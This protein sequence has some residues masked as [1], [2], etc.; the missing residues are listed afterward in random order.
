M[1]NIKRAAIFMAFLAI[2]CG[3]AMAA[4]VY[5]RGGM[6]DAPT[7]IIDNTPSADKAVWSGIELGAFL[8]YG[9]EHRE[10]T[11]DVTGEGGSTELLDLQGLSAM[12]LLA[13][14]E[15]GIYRQ[16]GRF[17]VGADVSYEWSN[18]ET[19][20]SIVGQTAT[21][22]QG[23]K[24][25]A[26][27]SIGVLVTD[28]ALLYVKGGYVN[29]TGAELTIPG[30]DKI[31]LD[32]DGLYIGGGA[33]I[34]LSKYMKA[35]IEYIHDFMNEDNIVSGQG[36]AIKHKDDDDTIRVGLTYTLGLD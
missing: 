16:L 13:G 36:F 22:D 31:K 25:R 15:V 26:G 27:G 14:A 18:M 8:G 10:I 32:T 23:E 3:F 19:N 33:K 20:L 2:Q 28:S 34:A 6:K 35:K 11:A 29:Q 1:Q 7:S 9:Q 24:L 30:E 12:G 17:V 5:S 4:D 21:W